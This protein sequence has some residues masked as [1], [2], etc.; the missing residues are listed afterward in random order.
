MPFFLNIATSPSRNRVCR[1]LIRLLLV[2]TVYIRSS[3]QRE[4]FAAFVPKSP[5]ILGPHGA[6][7]AA[8]PRCPFWTANPAAKPTIRTHTRI[9]ERLKPVSTNCFFIN[10][11]LNAPGHRA[12]YGFYPETSEAFAICSSVGIINGVGFGWRGRR[13]LTKTTAGWQKPGTT[14]RRTA[15]M[16]AL[17]WHL[18]FWD[19]TIKESRRTMDKLPGHFKL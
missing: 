7:G 13:T 16:A 14:V 6:A 12:G 1:S 3:K 2:S 18:L 15:S 9:P 19:T 10:L 17:W 8:G 5:A 11:L 4:L